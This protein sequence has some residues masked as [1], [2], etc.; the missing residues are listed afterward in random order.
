MRFITFLLTS[1]VMLVAFP[2][3]SSAAKSPVGSWLGT[4][5]LSPQA[6]LRIV[7]NVTENSNGSYSVTM[8]SPDQGAKGIPC[9]TNY[10]SADSINVSVRSI[11]FSYS[12]RIEGEK[13]TG[14]F[15]QNGMKL[16][17]E[18]TY[19]KAEAMRPQTP[20][21]PFP[22]SERSVKF[23]NANALL[24]GT[25]LLPQNFSAD[26]PVVLMITGSGQQ[27][28]DEEVFGHK[29]FWVI[30][31]YLARNDIGSLRYDDRGVG[32]STGDFKTATTHDF[33][34][35]AA[36]GIRYLKNTEGF[37]N[38]GVLGHSEGGA[39]AFMLG[40]EKE[41]RYDARPKFIVTLGAPAM[42][43]D[44]LLA[45][46]NE[47]L[48]KG[49]GVSAE[50]AAL[51]AEALKKLYDV[52]IHQGSKAACASVDDITKSW[53]AD[54]VLAQLKENLRQVAMTENPWFDYFQS[55]SPAKAIAA[56]QCPV[57]ALYG[58]KDIQVLPINAEA[59]KKL[60]GKVDVRVM[61]DRNHLMQTAKTGMME[62]Y[63]TIEETISPE[64]LETIVTFINALK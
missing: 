37:R 18:L 58:G 38:V 26:T 35:D 11:G 9:Q 54:P 57:L 28:R 17:L 31:D 1:F 3:S 46:Q 13:M 32:E 47:A 39:I 41:F 25:L 64:V 27:N 5:Q 61:P 53:P 34:L 10:L 20:K 48:L 29:P 21:P 19:V 15:S 63:E 56:T 12:G 14:S 62:E 45:D 49:R 7:F 4:L 51:Y 6:K 50:T 22:Y 8:D 36:E 33:A 2:Q 16:P 59:L 60:N 24:A 42:R 30:A 44:S 23:G 40:G 55:Y 43:G 52:K